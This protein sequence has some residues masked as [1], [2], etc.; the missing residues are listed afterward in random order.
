MEE[1]EEGS[2]WKMSGPVA[3]VAAVDDIVRAIVWKIAYRS[4][5]R[6][7]YRPGTIVLDLPP[8]RVPV[9]HATATRLRISARKFKRRA[10][11]IQSDTCYGT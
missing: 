7:R 6:S 9:V 8:V 5:R 3:A 10:R 1:D 4:T 2:S 11:S